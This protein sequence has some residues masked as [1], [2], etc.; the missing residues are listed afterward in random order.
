MNTTQ[1][2]AKKYVAGLITCAAAALL[3]TGCSTSSTSTPSDS[4]AL[5]TKKVALPSAF[6]GQSLV[7]P[8]VTGY[9]PYAYVEDGNIVGISADLAT[10]VGGPWGQKVTLKQDSFE[11]ALLGV[12]SGKYFGAFGADVTAAR[13]QAF[14][15]V[16]FLEDHYQF[17]GLKGATLGSAM[18]DLCGKSVSVVAAD[19]AIPVLQTQSGQCTAEGKKAIDVKT[20]ADQGAAT[21]AVK[22]KQVDLTTATFTN[23]GFIEKQQPG[24]FVIVGPK[25]QSVLIGIATQKGNGMAQ[26]LADSINVLI[27][28]GEYAKILK[29]YG[30]SGAAITRAEVNPNPNVG[31]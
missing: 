31:Q 7:A 27:D 17:M 26:S 10:A 29:R 15:Q 18:S 14:D 8:A 13:E 30:V 16:S 3:L 25:Y 6:V 22:S 24:Q 11:N 12:N 5:A 21:L 9:P 20:F 4:P 19:S 2:S 28:N 23:L 1:H